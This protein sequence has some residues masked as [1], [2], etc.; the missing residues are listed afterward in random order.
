MKFSAAVYSSKQPPPHAD[1]KPLVR[2]IVGAFGEDRIIWGGLGMNMADFEKQV[3]TFETLLGF[4][5]E[6]ARA[7]IRGLNAAKLY[8]FE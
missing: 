8:G 1:L 2:R 7:R 3:L 6:P 5:P 4:M